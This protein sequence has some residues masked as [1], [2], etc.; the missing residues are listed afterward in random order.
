MNVGQVINVVTNLFFGA[1]APTPESFAKRIN[2]GDDSAIDDI[3]ALSPNQQSAVFND[4]SVQ[5]ALLIADDLTDVLLDQR[6]IDGLSNAE[7][8]LTTYQQMKIHISSDTS[9]IQ[10]RMGNLFDRFFPAL[11]DLS[12][13]NPSGF[14]SL[15]DTLAIFSD[16]R[17]QAI[18]LDTIR[19]KDFD[20]RVE[21]DMERM[22]QLQT[23]HNS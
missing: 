11:L 10:S 12:E 7:S 1:T 21:R 6:V 8:K 18:I 13:P 19:N 3:F 4:A 16:P 2:A 23:D 22:F 14:P 17:N 15:E 9:Q 5:E 20:A